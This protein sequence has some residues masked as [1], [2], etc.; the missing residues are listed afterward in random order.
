MK[1]KKDLRSSAE[2][3]SQRRERICT[4][5]FWRW[6]WK[7]TSVSIKIHVKKRYDAHHDQVSEQIVNRDS[8][9]RELW[10]SYLQSPVLTLTEALRRAEMWDDAVSLTKG[11]RSWVDISAQLLRDVFCWSAYAD[12]RG[13]VC[14]R[15]FLALNKRWEENFTRLRVVNWCSV[16]LFPS[17]MMWTKSGDS[18]LWME[19][20]GLHWAESSLHFVTIF[21][22]MY[23]SWILGFQLL[24]H[25]RDSDIDVMNLN[26]GTTQ[27]WLYLLRRFFNSSKF[28]N[29]GIT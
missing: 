8:I 5:T 13:V 27:Y 9:R 25:S 22:V 28:K 6:T 26:W 14:E 24:G 19:S 17:R 23:L 11:E 4:L 3:W 21:D 7:S 2:T 18:V 10:F 1:R 20:W 15:H 16:S 29:L 12:V